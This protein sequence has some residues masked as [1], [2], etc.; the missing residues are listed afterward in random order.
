MQKIDDCLL[1]IKTYLVENEI[2]CK[3]KI[4][5][6]KKTENAKN[7]ENTKNI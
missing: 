3:N 6:T 4:K 2:G 5:N 7:T 1:K